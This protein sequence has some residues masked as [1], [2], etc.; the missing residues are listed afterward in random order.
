MVLNFETPA[1]AT[2]G[3]VPAGSHWIATWGAS[4]QAATVG[5]L[6]RAGFRDATVREIVLTSAGGVRLRIRL[7]NAFGA[8]P[9]RIGQAAV[10]LA[11][12]GPNTVPGTSRAVYFAG[13]RSV[14]I[15]PGAEAVSDPVPLAVPAATRRP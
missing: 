10:A 9:L 7:T 4:P 11:G 13:G 8:A 6:S 15:P 12:S 2:L 3:P 5:N 14:L 1:A